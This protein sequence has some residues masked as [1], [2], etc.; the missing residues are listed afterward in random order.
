MVDNDKAMKAIEMFLQAIGEDPNREGLKDTPNRVARM[1]E[2]LTSGYSLDA[3]E[4]LSKVFEVDHSDLVL[5]KDINFHSLCEHHMLPFMGKIH[6]AYIPN[7]K[8]VGLSKLARTVEVFARRLQLQERL[9]NQIADSIYEN[10]QAK[11]V[12]VIVGAEHTCMSMR[13][14]KKIGAKT[15]SYSSK[16]IFKENYQL[17]KNVLDLIKNG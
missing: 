3:K 12:F 14:I 4:P 10:L 7:G 5:V 16:G 9:T 13:G 1:Y 6:I 17:Q 2:E 15:T 8:V 11:G